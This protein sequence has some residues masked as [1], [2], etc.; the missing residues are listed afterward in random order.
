[1][2][3]SKSEKLKEILNQTLSPQDIEEK[4]KKEMENNIQ[5]KKDEE[6]EIDITEKEE[7]RNQDFSTNNIKNESKKEPLEENL[8]TKSKE[9]KKEKQNVN[10]L[11]YLIIIITLLLFAIVIYLY[12]NGEKDPISKNEIIKEQI[13]EPEKIED[14]IILKTVNTQDSKKKED[15]NL[16]AEPI[17]KEIPS[18]VQKANEIVKIK[19]VIKEK[20]VTKIVDLDKKNF[21]KFYNSSKYNTLKCYKFKSAD[22]FPDSQCKA[23]LTKFLKNNANALRFEVVPVIAEDDDKIFLKMQSNIQ[24]MDESF[25]KKVKEYMYKGLSRDRVL[26]TSWYIKDQLGEDTI[27]TPTNYY[28]KS[29]KDNKGVIIKAYY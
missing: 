18:E 24:S 5:K 22:V 27:L 6:K 25:Q 23:D 11:L 9:I 19:E 26:E 13:A 15:L 4:L 7:L 20:I 17:K 16:M 1:M 10:M 14:K 12:S 2:D 3:K 8:I 29:K 28:V 21:K